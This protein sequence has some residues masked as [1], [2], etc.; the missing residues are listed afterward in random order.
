MATTLKGRVRRVSLA[1]FGEEWNDAFVEFRYLTW[2]D[3]Q[4]EKERNTGNVE[5]SDAYLGQAMETLQRSF[6][7]GKSL[8][9]QG[10]LVDLVAE[11]LRGFDIDALLNL[12]QRVLGVPDPNV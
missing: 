2:A 10:E 3:A 4:A 12:Y 7:S 9:D 8:N 1:Y 6:V 11:D 5:N